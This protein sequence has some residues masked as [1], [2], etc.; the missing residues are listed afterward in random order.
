M[1]LHQLRVCFT[2]CRWDRA[3]ARSHE[4]RGLPLEM[5]DGTTGTTR[6]RTVCILVATFSL[7]CG[8]RTLHAATG[9]ILAQFNAQVTAGLPACPAGTGIAYDGTS[10]ILSCQTAQILQRVD[11][12]TLANS[13][14]VTIS[15]LPPSGALGALAWDA[16]R[17]RLWACFGF[18]F[19]RV[20]AIQ[21]QTTMVGAIAGSVDTLL[22]PTPINISGG[23]WD[24][25]AY[26]GSDDTLWASGDHAATVSHYALNGALLSPSPFSVIN[27]PLLGGNFGNSGIAV[28]GSDLF[29]ANDRGSKIYRVP[30]NF[31]GSTLFASASPRRVED[32]ECDNKTFAPKGAIWSQD[33]F[34]RILTAYEI[35]P[36][37]CHFGGLPPSPD[38]FTCYT[39]SGTVGQC[40]TVLPT[41]IPCTNDTMC[42]PTALP[43]LGL[44]ANG[45]AVNLEDQFALSDFTATGPVRLCAPTDKN[46]EGISDPNTHL[47]WYKLEG[48][49]A[50]PHAML[51]QNQFGK[52]IVATHAVDSLLVPTAKSAIGPVNPPDPTQHNVDHY[53]CYHATLLDNRCQGKPAIACSGD[54]DCGAFAPCIGGFNGATV[55]IT[56][57]FESA[58]T[59]ELIKKARLCTPV[60]KNGE[61]IKNPAVHLLCYRTSF[62][63]LVLGPFYVN[64]Q[65]GPERLRV[66]VRRWFCVPSSKTVLPWLKCGNHKLNRRE[67][68]D[69][70]Q[71][72]CVQPGKTCNQ[73]CQCVDPPPVLAPGRRAVN[74]STAAVLGTALSSVPLT[75]TSTQFILD[76]GALNAGGEANI[77]IAAAYSSFGSWFT[78]SAGGLTLCVTQAGDGAGRLCCNAA[79]CPGLGDKSFGVNQDHDSSGTNSAQGFLAGEVGPADQTCTAAVTN[80]V[81]TLPANV[82]TACHER[83]ARAGACNA[84]A[85]LSGNPN[86]HAPRCSGGVRDGRFCDP[87]VSLAVE[88]PGGS[89][90]ASQSPALPGVPLPGAP[91][92][93][94]ATVVATPA[95]FADGDMVL[96]MPLQLTVHRHSNDSIDY[97]AG[98][99][100]L[101]GDGKPDGFGC[102]G[103][104]CTADDMTPPNDPVNVVW[105]TGA[106]S[107]TVF[108]ANMVPTGS[109]GSLA[110]GALTGVV[111]ASACSRLGS[112]DTTGY[113]LVGAFPMLDD[114]S[115]G[116]IAFALTQTWTAPAFTD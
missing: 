101:A 56:N 19:V 107:A 68:C 27:P 8:S 35:P 65:F 43:C 82:A 24:G 55:S 79:G 36:V 21:Y 66:G 116:D 40:N 81:S 23:C 57:Q 96:S 111:P 94:P 64:N 73:F 75:G 62:K 45:F 88:C 53:K 103:I 20:V 87:A 110:T 61:G 54:A 7:V 80:I 47:K 102:D 63:R 12:V 11:P 114:A 91:C 13:G 78:P 50:A 41:I 77:S 74:T 59:V 95:P 33:A 112:G 52:V 90:C 108:D 3:F 42:P 69:G 92:N 115:L 109:G 2:M 72:G 14:T 25:L 22:T 1:K 83:E 16:T 17:N 105:T 71:H 58:P 85:L 15:G 37:L 98:C 67:Q 89:F 31:S 76:V 106:T 38:H 28:G 51:I 6:L 70:P 18:G 4:C 93:G 30:K 10:L 26:D 34:D 29:L 49:L 99:A 9:D 5:T 113:T 97:G 48:S 39:A 104:A 46:G 44:P 84:D 86:S 32:L 100:N 60:D